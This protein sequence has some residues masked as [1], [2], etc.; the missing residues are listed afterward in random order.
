MTA[1]S[2]NRLIAAVH[3]FT[4]TDFKENTMSTRNRIYCVVGLMMC[5]SIAAEA[6]SITFNY[7]VTGNANATIVGTTLS[8]SF[9]PLAL[10]STV[11]GPLDVR[12]QGEIDLSLVPP[13]G[14]TTSQ[15]SL[16]ALGMFF[17]TGLEFT[18]APDANGIIP[19][20]GTSVI[21]GG[22]GMFA[23]ATGN[24]MYDGLFNSVTG[25]ASFSETITVNTVPEPGTLPLLGAALAG[26]MAFAGFTRKRI[27]TGDAARPS[28]PRAPLT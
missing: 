14:P 3:W 17:G 7:S 10:P 9:V 4:T 12:Y 18:G 15:W 23:G 26:A 19:F 27:V 11:L 28:D 25:I 16:G 22:T 5:F 6:S 1:K 13:N 21:N 8:Y 20:F 2:V 24:T